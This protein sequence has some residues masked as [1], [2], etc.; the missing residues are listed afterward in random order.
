MS[1]L[2][3]RELNKTYL[4]LSNEEK[5]YE[6]SYEL[7]MIAKNTP[8]SFLSLHVMRVDGM[9][10]LY[11]DVSAKQTLWEF[12]KREKLSKDLLCHLFESMERMYHDVRE[13][14]LD[15]ESVVLDLQH[16]YIQ[17]ERFYFCYCP[18]EQK[19][20]P[21]ALRRLLE[22]IL[23]HLDYHDTKGVELAYHF[24]QSACK[25]NL[26]IGEILKEHSES[27]EPEEAGILREEPFWDVSENR[28]IVFDEEK[29]NEVYKPKS[30]I[31]HKILQF[32]LKKQEEPEEESREESREFP[33]E[34]V[35]PRAGRYDGEKETP[36][37]GEDGNTTVLGEG[38]ARSW[39]L[40]PMH[41]GYESFEIKGE[42]FVVGKKK[43]IVDGYIS[44]NT[45]SRIHSRLY[46]REGRLFISDANSTNGTCVNG[47]A[48]EPGEEQ[49]IF[50]GDRILFADVGYEC[51]NSL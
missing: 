28:E 14:L 19:E 29:R 7:Q 38:T 49:E 33:I 36:C 27:P 5:N 18:W 46:V 40:Q 15:A 42:C 12:S 50:S 11:Y 30:G 51:Y 45:I 20:P 23:E 39:R 8:E 21:E 25:G 43:E 32:F 13:F 22:E 9:L 26:Q 4:I 37:F 17:E 31:F 35:Y 16:I 34:E 41:A 24:Y 6:E 3:K 2:L 1:E 48:L 44:R 47:T 10:Q